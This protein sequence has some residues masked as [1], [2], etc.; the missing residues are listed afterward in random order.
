MVRRKGPVP[1]TAYDSEAEEAV[2]QKCFV[3]IEDK[4]IS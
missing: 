2:Y 1:M 4:D 3:C